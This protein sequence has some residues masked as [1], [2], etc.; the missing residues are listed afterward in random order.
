MEMEQRR[1]K[2][3]RPRKGIAYQPAKRVGLYVGE[4][5]RDRLNRFRVSLAA[6]IGAVEVTQD[7]A[8][9]I[10]LDTAEASA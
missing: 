4:P 8:I 6:S 5:T 3:G 1:T 2:R 10:L 7:E 9:S